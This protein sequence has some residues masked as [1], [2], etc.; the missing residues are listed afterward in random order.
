MRHLI[1]ILS[2]FC[3]LGLCAQKTT[4]VKKTVVYHA[5]LHQSVEQAKQMAVE[6]AKVEAINSVFGAQVK[7]QS[8]QYME[9]SNEKEVDE[10]VHFST[11]QVR[12]RWIQDIKPASFDR[13]WEEDNML[14]VTVTV[15]GQVREITTSP[16][17]CRVRVLCDGTDADNERT[18]FRN[19]NNLY[20][21][22]AS[23]V[24]G[25]LVVYLV[26]AQ[27]DAYCALPY[28]GQSI[29]A[30][31]IE[32]N[33]EYLFFDPSRANAQ[34][35]PYVEG[36]KLDTAGDRETD[37]LYVIFSPNKFTKAIDRAGDPK[38]PRVLSWDE[39]HKWLSHCLNYD[40]EMTG[41]QPIL[42]HITK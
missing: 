10:F 40:D 30:Y 12:G 9:K 22:F 23:P 27:H 3:V 42:L 25:Y 20:L 13:I 36:Y 39:F 4:K 16:I 41:E 34:D 5:E 15:E 14:N 29:G 24:D 11:T 26:D 37:L 21:S 19:G 35:R 32:A 2:F 8:S 1:A 31:P 6:Y 18:D 28:Y 7:S 38:R 17:P 33:H